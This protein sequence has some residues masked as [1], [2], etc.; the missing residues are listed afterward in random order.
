[1]HWSVGLCLL[2]DDPPRIVAR[3]LVL[4]GIVGGPKAARVINGFVVARVV[5]DQSLHEVWGR[6]KPYS[7]HPASA[8]IAQRRV[9]RGESVPFTVLIHVGPH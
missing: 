2:S 3:V 7:G 4:R 6:S 5:S 8:R 1:M 9:G